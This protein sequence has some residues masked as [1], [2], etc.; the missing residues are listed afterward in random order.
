MHIALKNTYPTVE[1]CQKEFIL[2]MM[3]YLKVIFYSEQLFL[4]A[5]FDI[6]KYKC[7]LLLKRIYIFWESLYT[8]D[9]FRD[10]TTLFEVLVH[11]ELFISNNYVKKI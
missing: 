9:L 10:L 2:G 11:I 6:L 1:K 7:S 8:T 3:A 5:I 4:I